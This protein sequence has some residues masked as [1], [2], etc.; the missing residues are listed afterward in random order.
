VIAA[1]HRFRIWRRTRPFW[2]GLVV[3]I[4][5]LEELVSERAPFS[6]VTHIGIPGLTGYLIPTFILLCGVLLWSMPI[7]R[8]YYSVLTILLALVSWTTSNL[9]G[10]LFGMLIDMV[11]GALAFAWTTNTDNSWPLRIRGKP[12]IGLPSWTRDLVFQL[13]PSHLGIRSPAALDTRRVERPALPAPRPPATAQDH[14]SHHPARAA[15]VVLRR[16]PR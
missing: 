3:I 12:H 13:Q 4:G 6:L 15:D 2:G 5:A 8:V 14:S 10:Y 7:A 11:G 1:W 16:R 9:G